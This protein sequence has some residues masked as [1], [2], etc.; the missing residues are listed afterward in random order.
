R[1]LAAMEQLDEPKALDKIL[2]ILNKAASVY[3]KEKVA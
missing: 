1:E 3:N 2:E